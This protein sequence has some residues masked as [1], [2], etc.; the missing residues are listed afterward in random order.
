MILSLVQAVN[1]GANTH[2]FT[3]L[4]VNIA[5]IRDCLMSSDIEILDGACSRESWLVAGSIA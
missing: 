5:L 2:H 4:Q 3:V 1:G